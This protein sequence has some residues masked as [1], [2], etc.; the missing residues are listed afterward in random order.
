MQNRRRPGERARTHSP[1]SPSGYPLDADKRLR[2][3]AAFLRQSLGEACRKAEK[4]PCCIQQAESFVGRERAD[5]RPG[6]MPTQRE[7]QLMIDIEDTRAGRRRNTN[8]SVMLADE[9]D[10]YVVQY[11]S[12]ELSVAIRARPRAAVQELAES[13][14]RSRA[15][16]ATDAL[17]DVPY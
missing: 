11:L 5:C 13:I 1:H 3:R 15:P 7:A 2:A 12:D 8:L 4:F 9:I 10:A 14:L 6:E 16:L 17:E